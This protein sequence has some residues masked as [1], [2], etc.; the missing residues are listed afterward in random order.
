MS[1]KEEK[2]EENSTEDMPNNFI[3]TYASKY[4]QVY[5][6]GFMYEFRFHPEKTLQENVAALEFLLESAKTTL[7]KE[8][9]KEHTD[10]L[11]E[12]KD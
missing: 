3:Q 7:E 8:K 5:F 10:A 11:P 6:E 12:A 4:Y 9:E 2:K 1:K